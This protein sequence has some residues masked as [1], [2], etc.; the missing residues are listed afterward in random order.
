MGV[1]GGGVWVQ[2]G[3]RRGLQWVSEEHRELFC[4][5]GLNYVL[6]SSSAEFLQ[7]TCV[8]QDCGVF[9]AGALKSSQIAKQ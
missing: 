9:L 5:Q 6:Q 4:T 7:R 8:F 3:R 1:G 2:G